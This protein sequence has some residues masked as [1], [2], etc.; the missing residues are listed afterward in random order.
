MTDFL[1]IYSHSVL[2]CSLEYITYTIVVCI[3]E[4][5]GQGPGKPM[6]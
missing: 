1:F 5:T 6:T 3:I 4:G 2:L